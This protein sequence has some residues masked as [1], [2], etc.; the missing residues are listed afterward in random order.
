MIR[1]VGSRYQNSL[2]L[3]LAGG[4]AA[5]GGDLQDQGNGRPKFS[6]TKL[7]PAAVRCHFSE[8]S[9]ELLSYTSNALFVLRNTADMFGGREYLDC[10]V[11][12]PC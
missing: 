9:R 10:S 5:I 3:A 1:C 6:A 8:T 12:A 11:I 4:S 2:K 7:T